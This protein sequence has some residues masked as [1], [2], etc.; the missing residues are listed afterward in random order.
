MTLQFNDIVKS[1][2]DKRSHR[3]VV[4]ENGMKC[5]LTSDADADMAAASLSV[6]VGDL[7]NPDDL[8]GLAHFCEHLLFMGTKKV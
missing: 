3:V 4:L 8:P 1:K 7:M 2:S 5:M 6:Q